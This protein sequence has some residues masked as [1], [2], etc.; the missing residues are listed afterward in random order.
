MSAA[1]V[2]S[3][4][5]DG[6]LYFRTPRNEAEI[7]TFCAA[8]ENVFSTFGEAVPK[9]KPGMLG[10]TDFGTARRA[11]Y[12]PGEPIFGKTGT[13][14]HARTHLGW[15]G[16]FNEVGC[17]NSVVVLLTGGNLAGVVRWPL[18]LRGRSTRTSPSSATLPVRRPLPPS[19]SHRLAALASNRRAARGVALILFIS[20]RHPEAALQPRAA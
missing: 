1:L 10:A 4:A 17:A 7:D 11:S 15:F 16:S 18:A 9:M 19:G 2:T 8:C 20:A 5:N 12:D 14:S 3:I 13:C 6:T